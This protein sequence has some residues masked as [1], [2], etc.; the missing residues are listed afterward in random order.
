M[1]VQ[2][3]VIRYLLVVNNLET[4]ALSREPKNDEFFMQYKVLINCF[5][6]VQLH[7]LSR[8]ECMAG[9]KRKK[10]ENFHVTAE[11]PIGKYI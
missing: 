8:D 10:L 2:V 1:Q 6:T 9:K 3:F 4:V 5:V 7:K 11:N